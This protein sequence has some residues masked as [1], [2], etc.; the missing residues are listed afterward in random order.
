MKKIVQI[1]LFSF[2]T[3]GVISCSS[4]GIE[5]SISTKD[6]LEKV[7]QIMI[8]KFG[9]KAEF[10]ELDL[11]T[12]SVSKT[13]FYQGL[14]QN[15][16]DYVIYSYEYD[17]VVKQATTLNEKQK[18]FKP[19]TLSDFNVDEFIEIKNKAIVLIAQ[20]SKDFD[21]FSIERLTCSVKENGE[22]KYYFKIIGN[23]ISENI[24]YVGEKLKH[25]GKQY[26]FTF[27]YE[28][29][30]KQLESTTKGFK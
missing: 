11:L 23:K 28:T 4:S 24:S 12:Q 10:I 26:G 15:K 8:D 13:L 6:D 17:N 14:F 29:D 9:E 19:L 20:K 3:F 30:I 22:R 25:G 27:T 7:K 2:L 21:N 18:S 1:I 16:T 5:L